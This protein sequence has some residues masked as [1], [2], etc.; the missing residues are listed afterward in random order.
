MDNIEITCST[1]GTVRAEII[2]VRESDDA[3][4]EIVCKCPLCKSK[5]VIKINQ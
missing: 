4:K 1:C 3:F 5:H 2:E